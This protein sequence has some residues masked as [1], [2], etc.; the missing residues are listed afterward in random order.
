MLWLAL[1]WK[2]FKAQVVSGDF[3]IN[4]CLAVGKAGAQNCSSEG[5]VHRHLSTELQLV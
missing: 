2:V 5:T 1:K 4:F 3:T